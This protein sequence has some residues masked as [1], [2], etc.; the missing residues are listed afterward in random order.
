MPPS[1][2]K[3]ITAFP[4]TTE[5]SIACC[6]GCTFAIALHPYAW[7][8]LMKV[9]FPVPLQF[10]ALLVMVHLYTLTAP[11]YRSVTEPFGTADNAR[12]YVPCAVPHPI[13]SPQLAIPESFTCVHEAPPSSVF[14]IPRSVC[15]LSTNHTYISLRPGTTAI[16]PR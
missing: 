6:A 9:L 7:V 8:R 15:A 12:S 10:G 1:L 14:Q 16:S 11:A 13:G 3:Y 2:A 5:K 4:F